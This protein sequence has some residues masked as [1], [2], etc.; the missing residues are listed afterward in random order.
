VNL[1]YFYCSD[2]ADLLYKANSLSCSLP[3]ACFFSAPHTRCMLSPDKGLPTLVFS[4]FSES[5]IEENETH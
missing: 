2:N 5:W 4:V 3:P 1:G